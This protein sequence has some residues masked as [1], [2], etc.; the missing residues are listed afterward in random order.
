VQPV[1][2][3]IGL[4]GSVNRP[5]IL[6]MKPGETIADVLRMGGGF[7]A[8]ADRTRLAVERLSDR[9]TA[10]IRELV[11]PADLGATLDNGDVVRAFSA[12]EAILPIQQQNKRVRVEGEVLRPG[13]YV[14]P[15]A[16]TI[17]DAI[18]AAG[19]LTPAAYV[20]GT[21]FSRESV[22][23]TQQDNYE[24]ALRDLE[25]EF[26]RQGTQRAITAD[27]A[28]AATARSAANSRLVERLRTVK[29]TGRIVLQLA[30]NSIDLPPLALENGD[31]LFIPPRP[32]TVGVFGSVFNGGSYL[33]SGERPIEDYLR[34]A[35]G[36]TRGADQGSAFVIRANGIVVSNL[37]SNAGWWQRQAGLNG[38]K[39][40]PGDT[41]F[42]PE[43]I[44]KTTFLQSAK[45]WTQ[46]LSQFALGAAAIQILK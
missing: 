17:A 24:R 42:V 14:L 36:P 2:T 19:G 30:P 4:I 11:L 25:T 20:Y 43:E 5:A 1:G 38:L 37:Q 45:D 7:T 32:T 40:E 22:R 26:A 41:I 18:K 28:A 44:N 46:V 6:E 29:P 31:R 39:A 8:V 23:L 21:E 10:R 13:D 9:S 16:S 33:F 3:E 34:L 12:V 27:E 35:G 15:A